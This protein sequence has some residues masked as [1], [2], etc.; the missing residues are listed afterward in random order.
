MS[1]QL[2]ST[3]PQ[4]A[5]GPTASATPSRSGPRAAAS[6]GE[7]PDTALAA[8][9]RLLRGHAA[10]RRLVAADLHAD[11]GLTVNEYEALQML[12]EADGQRLRGIDLAEGLKLTPSGVTR[13]L[14]GLRAL[15]L[16]EKGACP[17]DARVTY[18]VLTE[19]G[20]EKLRAATCTH[21]RLVSAL[22]E[23]RYTRAELTTLGELLARLPGTGQPEQSC[24]LEGV[25]PGR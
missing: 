22:L 1:H 20:A 12:G 4:R 10:M 15:G 8:W 25:S 9:V 5:A 3:Q 16:V 17:S 24:P 19:S 13:L 2:L 21:A 14:D 11:H 23:Q 7:E 18:A 6:G